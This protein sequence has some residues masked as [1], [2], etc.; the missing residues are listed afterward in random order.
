MLRIVLIILW[1]MRDLTTTRKYFGSALPPKIQTSLGPRSADPLHG[2]C[3]AS[4]QIPHHPYK[5]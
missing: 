1:A 2:L 3:A 5:I 4:V